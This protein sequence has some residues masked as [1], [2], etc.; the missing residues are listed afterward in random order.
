MDVSL[1][2]EL[3]D[4]VGRKVES[5]LYPSASEVIHEGL[6]LLKENDELRQRQLEELRRE[7]ALGLEDFEQGRF[8]TFN[9]E[10]LAEIQAEGRKRLAAERGRRT[11]THE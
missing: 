7:I 3:E 11:K 8:S 5:G 4:Y 2:P 9:E 1:P 10:T 6:R